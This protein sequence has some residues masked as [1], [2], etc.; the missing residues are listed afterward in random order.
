[1]VKLNDFNK[2]DKTMK[3]AERFSIAIQDSGMY[4]KDIAEQLG[5]APAFISNLK[6]GIKHPSIHQLYKICLI[7][8]VSAD[9]LLGLSE[10]K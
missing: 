2:K 1:M 3:F 4:Q 8:D 7:L 6:K 9:Y 10:Y 5:V